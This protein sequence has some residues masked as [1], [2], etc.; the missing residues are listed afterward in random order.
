MKHR[1][2][3][4]GFVNS[5]KGILEAEL[6]KYAGEGLNAITFPVFDEQRGHYAI[7]VIDHPTYREPADVVILVR[8]AGD[9]IV[10]EEDMTDKKLVDA[11]LQQSVPREQIILAYNGE[12]APAPET[13]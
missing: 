1:S 6:L 7:A 12:V 10:I 4:E 11:L 13:T 9:K 8:M 2:L 3:K 5:L